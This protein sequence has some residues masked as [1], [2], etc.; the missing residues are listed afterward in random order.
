VHKRCA[1][2]KQVEP[3][4]S[5]RKS[6]VALTT[7]RLLSGDGRRCRPSCALG[8]VRRPKKRCRLLCPLPPRALGRGALALTGPLVHVGTN[9]VRGDYLP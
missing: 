2:S 3:C 4:G 7:L 5:K 1:L 8:M 9:Q 6:L